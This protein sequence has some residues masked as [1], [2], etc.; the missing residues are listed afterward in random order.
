MKRSGL[1]YLQISS[2]KTAHLVGSWA[3]YGEFSAFWVR[4]NRAGKNRRYQIVTL[5]L[6]V[7]AT[8][9]PLSLTARKNSSGTFEFVFQLSV[10]STVSVPSLVIQ[11]ETGPFRAEVLT[12]HL[13]LS[14]VEIPSAFVH[15]Q[16]LLGQELILQA[17]CCSQSVL[18]SPF[19]RVWDCAPTA[20]KFSTDLE[21]ELGDVLQE[22]QDVV[23]ELK[24]PSESKHHSYQ[25]VLH[26]AKSRIE[27]NGVEDS[28][29]S[30]GASMGN[31][32]NT[33]EEEL[34]H[35]GTTLALKGTA[36]LLSS[37]LRSDSAIVLTL[38]PQTLLPWAKA[39]LG[40]TDELESFISMLDQELA[41]T[42]RCCLSPS[43]SPL[44]R[45]V[46]R[47]TGRARHQEESQIQARA[48]PME[49]TLLSSL[50]RDRGGGK[51]RLP[52]EIKRALASILKCKST[53]RHPPA[54]Q[55]PASTATSLQH[56]VQ[57]HSRGTESDICVQVFPAVVKETQRSAMD[58]AVVK[59]TLRNRDEL[60]AYRGYP[61]YRPKRSLEIGNTPPHHSTRDKDSLK[62]LHALPG[63]DTKGPLTQPSYFVGNR[64]LRGALV[65]C[66]LMAN[67]S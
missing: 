37:H 39:K 28:D 14:N 53:L 45:D 11:H 3:Q 40:D 38:H 19:C 12:I 50:F 46:N 62:E 33:S 24:A 35:A 59:L 58:A 1:L 41:E 2:I 48:D 15:P 23:E 61:A 16:V 30:S 31:S 6:E 32:L 57:D 13:F 44:Y 51:K 10:W 26:E 66:H 60:A 34:H 8:G 36:S 21:L 9:W 64:H 17:L 42:V 47:D 29:Y 49:R 5:A 27:D 56:Q 52:S 67:S 4:S 7:N 22:F 63:S 54:I 20:V 43:L 25:R 65:D 55:R 18:E